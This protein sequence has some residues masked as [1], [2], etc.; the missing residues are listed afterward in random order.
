MAEDR[1]GWEY[2][3]YLRTRKLEG[4]MWP[5]LRCVGLHRSLFVQLWVTIFRVRNSQFFFRCRMQSANLGI[6]SSNHRR[7]S[8][9][10][11][12]RRFSFFFQ[13]ANLTGA[14]FVEPFL[15]ELE[16]LLERQC[17]PQVKCRTMPSMSDVTDVTCYR[18]WYSGCHVNMWRS[19]HYWHCQVQ[20]CV[21]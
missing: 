18:L 1:A 19:R 16:S 5:A 12:C 2:L 15:A 4:P 7:F 8:N 13:S 11:E 9:R 20:G 6:E 17:G 10:I 14:H 3:E 21:V